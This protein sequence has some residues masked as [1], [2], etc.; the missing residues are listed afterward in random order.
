MEDELILCKY[1]NHMT[2]VNNF[3]P[4]GLNGKYK[5][6]RGCNNE[7]SKKYI[8]KHKDEHNGNRREYIRNYMRR[9][10][11]KLNENEGE[12]PILSN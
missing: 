1:R 6:C 10:R 2:S 3:S 5:I 9:Y 12:G 11:D 8:R 4:S 7:K